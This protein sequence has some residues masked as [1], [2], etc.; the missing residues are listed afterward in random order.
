MF[1]AVA[2]SFSSEQRNFGLNSF[3]PFL[4]GWTG[5]EVFHDEHQIVLATEGFAQLVHGPGKVF[6]GSQ[7]VQREGLEMEGFDALAP[8]VEIVGAIGLAAFFQ[9][10][11]RPLVGLQVMTQQGGPGELGTWQFEHPPMEFPGFLEQGFG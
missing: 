11:P 7:F 5:P 8:A 6:R 10:L 2:Q 3:H 4:T 1:A 9:A